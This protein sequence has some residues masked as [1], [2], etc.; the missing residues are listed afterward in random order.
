MPVDL[1]L[2]ARG[3]STS[4]ASP[5]R[6]LYAGNLVP[7]KGVDLLIS[8][9]GRLRARGVAARLRILG[10]GPAEADL[11]ALARRE[12][13][14]DLVEW[15]RFVPQDAMTAEY[16]AATVTALPTRGRAEGLGLSLVEALLA[17]SAVVGSRVGGIPEVVQDGETGLLFGDGDVEGLAGALARLIQDHAL[18]DR[19]SAE[20]LRRVKD[21]YAPDSAARRFLD[22][23]DDI[24]G[25]RPS[26]P[27]AR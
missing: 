22:L 14:D 8:A 4:K 3:R 21:R 10:E 18:R 17:G 9:L 12:A 27:A 13:V 25:R 7:S 24:A 11:R 5:P 20:G 15:S 1:D 16:G 23:Y 6:I 19:L 26:R 2:F